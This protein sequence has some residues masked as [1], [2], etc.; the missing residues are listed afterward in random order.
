MKLAIVAAALF[1]A[2]PRAQ[3]CWEEVGERYG[4]HPQLLVA[5][6]R[7]ESGLNPNAVNKANANGSRDV[8]LMQINSAWLPRLKAMGIDEKQLLIPCVN[9]EVGA[10]I[11][12]QNMRRMGR[13]W[14]AVGAYN[15]ASPHKRLR[16]ARTVYRNLP[17]QLQDVPADKQ[18]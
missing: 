12:A 15:A 18:R 11:L 2:C 13:T 5:I 7:T 3:A 16:Y 14:E 8:G 1:L 10:W 6:A 9:L 4:I 17:P